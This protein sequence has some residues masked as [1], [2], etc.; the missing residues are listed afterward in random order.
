MSEFFLLTIIVI[1][2]LAISLFLFYRIRARR[3]S[4]RVGTLAEKVLEQIGKIENNL[5][6]DRSPHFE[7]RAFSYYK[8]LK[9]TLVVY[10]KETFGLTVR[11]RISESQQKETVAKYPE[12]KQEI[13]LL[14]KYFAEL[15]NIKEEQNLTKKQ[16][17][18]LLS[19]VKSLFEKKT[20]QQI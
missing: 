15:D 13:N 10:M 20:S 19:D 18:R 12:R 16:L 7:K 17:R 4:I 11:D 9:V 6:R 5:E 8:R 2:S 14:Q 1:V 3:S